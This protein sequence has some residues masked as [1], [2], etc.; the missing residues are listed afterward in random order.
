MSLNGKVALVTGAGRGIGRALATALAESGVRVACVARSE[1]ELS[2]TVELITS[3]GGSAVAVPADLGDAGTVP[4]VVHRVTAELGSPDLLVNNAATVEPL[5]PSTDMKPDAWHAAFT[6]NVITPAALSAALLPGMTGAGW[7][8]I[9]NVSSGIV[10]RPGTMIGGNA[11]AATKAALEAHSL[12][13]A[14][15]VAGTG[16]TVNVYRPGTVDT[17]MQAW[18]R[19]TGRGRLDGATY[20]RFVRNHE[21]G[22]LISSDDSARA[23]L[24]RLAGDATGQVWDVHDSR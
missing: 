17:A 16:V 24:D 1:D 18:I 9:V 20:T 8:R 10:A 13:L 7:G 19:R 11:Y 22:G 21:E 2:R 15:E 23:L 14:T 5:G 4:D 3:G 12:N 6:L